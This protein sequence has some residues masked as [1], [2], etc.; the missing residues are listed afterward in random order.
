MVMI[1][2]CGKKIEHAHYSFHDDKDVV[3]GRTGHGEP[4]TM[5]KK[6]TAKNFKK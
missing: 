2:S 6:R 4:M 1:C 3:L 5:P